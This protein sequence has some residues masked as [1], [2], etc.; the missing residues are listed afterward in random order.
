MQQLP[1][2]KEM[3]RAV[4]DSGT[5]YDGVFIVA[6]RTTGVF[7]RPSCRARKPLPKNCE[8]CGSVRAALFAGY[9]PCKRCR[10]LEVTGRPPDWVQRLLQRVDENPSARIRDGDL[11]ALGVDPTRARRYFHKHYGMTFHAFCRGRRMTEAFARIR[12]GVKL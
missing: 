7:C 4:R 2:T 8:Y 3:G 5:S 6:V 11:R 1:A 9:R 10:P 12:A